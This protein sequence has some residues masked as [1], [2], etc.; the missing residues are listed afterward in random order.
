MGGSVWSR[1]S[2]DEGVLHAIAKFIRNPDSMYE[3]H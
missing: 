1:F 3:N 2:I